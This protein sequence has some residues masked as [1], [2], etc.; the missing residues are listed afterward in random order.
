MIPRELRFALR[1]LGKAPGFTAG[2]IVMLALGMTLCTTALVVVKAYLLSGM[3]YPAA[4]RLFWIRYAA[5]GQPGPREMERLD[6]A[7][8]NDVLEHPVAWDL[9]MFYL[10]GGPG[11]E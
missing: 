8:L 10:L 11:A 6:W 7:S 1:S 5:P 4:E 2:A 3:P 9:D